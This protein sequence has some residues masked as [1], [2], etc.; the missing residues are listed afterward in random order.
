MSGSSA[1]W[2]GSLALLTDL[3]ELTMADGFLQTGVGN[4]ETVFEMFFR[5]NPFNG[6]YAVAA[7][8]EPVIQVLKN[9]YLIL[10]LK[11]R[12]KRT[13]ISFIFFS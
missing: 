3:Y 11:Q 5:K 9:Y 2:N 12:V 13:M 10:K 7:G 8:L 6:G 1:L 4:R